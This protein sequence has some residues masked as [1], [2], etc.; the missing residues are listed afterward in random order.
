MALFIGVDIGGTKVLATAVSRSGRVLRT[1]LRTTPGRRVEASLVEDALTEAVQEIAGIRRISAIGIAAAGFVDAQGERVRFAPHLPWRDEGVR[2]RLAERWSAPVVLDN[3]ANCAARAE[4]VY[5]AVGDAE[6]AL[7]ITLGTGIGGAV[8]LESTVHRGYN[9]MAGEFGH[10]QVVPDGRGCECGGAG[11][12]EQYCS[13]NALVRFVRERGGGDQLTG[14]MIT[15][16]AEAGDPLALEAFA[17]VGT[18]LGVGVANLVAAFDPEIVVI[19]GGLSAAGDL[20]LEPA[21]SALRTSLVGADHRTVPPVVRAALGPEAGAI[22]AADL[23]RQRF[24][25]AG[26]R[27]RARRQAARGTARRR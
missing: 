4:V 9:G 11:C 26:T 2:A 23:A 7:V 17:S 16:A 21:R 13:G 8:V 22:G 14:P 18:W 24:R 3:D 15:E 1:A 19:G 25:T 6:N 5:G 10:M 12:W 20:L 27:A